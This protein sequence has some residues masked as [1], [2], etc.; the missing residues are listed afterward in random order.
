MPQHTSP[1][2]TKPYGIPAQCLSIYHHGTK[3]YVNH[4]WNVQVYMCEFGRVHMRTFES[5]CLVEGIVG[6]SDGKADLDHSVHII[7]NP[8]RVLPSSGLIRSQ[9]DTAD[10]IQPFPSAN[11]SRP[12]GA[13]FVNCVR[14]SGHVAQSGTPPQEQGLSLHFRPS[15]SHQYSHPQML[16]PHGKVLTHYPN[17]PCLSPR[18]KVSD[19]RNSQIFKWLGQVPRQL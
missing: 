2:I 18:P 8:S 19:T 3:L 13:L 7:M 11:Q 4:Q 1:N 17:L 10:Y 5:L 6:I 15:R 14:H 9:H 12:L 16:P